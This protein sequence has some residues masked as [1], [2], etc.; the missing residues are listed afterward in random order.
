MTTRRTPLRR[1]MKRRLT[2]EAIDAFR[3]M[4]AL[5]A[6]CT[7]PARDWDGKPSEHR[8]CASCEE[9]WDVHKV[10]HDALGRQPHEWPC[11]EHPDAVCPYPAGSFAAGQWRRDERAVA[12]Y[13]ELKE[14]AA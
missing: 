8:S 12:L 7:C 4:E 13:R 11:I 10:L 1:D 14:A 9:W 3:R 2:P 5:R 6:A